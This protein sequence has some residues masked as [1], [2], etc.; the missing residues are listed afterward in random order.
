[1][2]LSHISDQS[3]HEGSGS[4]YG[5]DI[6]LLGVDGVGK[7][8]LTA[9]LVARLEKEGYEVHVVSW[10]KWLQTAPPGLARDILLPMHGAAVRALFA[11]AR[12]ADGLAGTDLLPP[13]IGLIDNAI[14]ADLIAQNLHFNDGTGVLAAMQLEAAASV[15]LRKLV[16]EPALQ[17]GCVVIQESYSY[18]QL[19]KQAEVAAHH[20]RMPRA[21]IVQLHITLADMMFNLCR[22]SLGV[23]LTGDLRFAYECRIKDTRGLGPIE[24]L[25]DPSLCAYENYEMLQRAA[26]QHYAT[27]ARRCGWPTLNMHATS[28]D[29]AVNEGVELVL[30]EITKLSS[31][32]LDHG[33]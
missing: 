8:T 14:L 2:M 24:H 16:V 32:P 27:F 29:A 12:T 13:D 9:T 15:L 26:Q 3:A 28:L 10:R 21:A 5:L 4:P 18:K 23:F 6:G 33:A 7:S 1:M 19:V 20:L 25:G 30:A 17:R 11:D 22:P 31:T